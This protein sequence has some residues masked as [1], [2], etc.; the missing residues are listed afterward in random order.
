[1]YLIKSRDF[2]FI[3]VSVERRDEWKATGGDRICWACA[4]STATGT[5]YVSWYEFGTS[6]YTR[7]V[8]DYIRKRYEYLYEDGTRLGMLWYT[9]WRRSC[10]KNRIMNVVRALCAWACRAFFMPWDDRRSELLRSPAFFARFFRQ[11]TGRKSTK[12]KSAWIEAE[13]R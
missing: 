11:M 10:V 4:Q 12:E 5:G 9:R 13:Q 8:R 3:K 7:L 1:M 6:L 2:E